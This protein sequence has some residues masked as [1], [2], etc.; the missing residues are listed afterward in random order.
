VLYGQ[1]HASAARIVIEMIIATA[2]CWMALLVGL[3]AHMRS[4]GISVT[5]DWLF[6]FFVLP[7]LTTYPATW[8]VILLER[9]W[10]TLGLIRE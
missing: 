10:A 6:A 1:R 3:T 4:S 5:F 7:Y 9:L 2:A 8:L